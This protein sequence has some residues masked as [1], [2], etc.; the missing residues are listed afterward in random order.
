MRAVSYL[1]A[2]TEEQVEEGHSMD[3]QRTSTR[4]FIEGHGWDLVHE[5]VD[6]G[7]SAKRDSERPA[8]ERLLREAAR[9]DHSVGNGLAMKEPRVVGLGLHRVPKRMTVVEDAPQPAFLF[10]LVHHGGF[11]PNRLGDDFLDDIGLQHCNGFHAAADEIDGIVL[12]NRR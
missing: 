9:G 4:Q 12:Q 3:A 10:V 1:R 5:Y 11:D 2:S 7:L 6:A 8:L